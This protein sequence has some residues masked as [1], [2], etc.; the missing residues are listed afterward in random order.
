MDNEEEQFL[1]K[2]KE[3]VQ[4][5]SEA[6]KEV[7]EGL[8]VKQSNLIEST[9]TSSTLDDNKETSTTKDA[10]AISVSEQEDSA[11][12]TGA[13]VGDLEVKTSEGLEITLTTTAASQELS[14]RADVDQEN[15]VEIETEIS[16]LNQVPDVV[17]ETNETATVTTPE[18]REVTETTT[19]ATETAETTT[20]QENT[21][22]KEHVPEDETVGYC[23]LENEKS[24]FRGWWK[25]L[26]R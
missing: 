23:I 17:A 1:T 12:S 20:E 22:T 25:R 4:N 3:N 5:C 19:I 14:K 26:K 8:D 9:A 13:P 24:S 18:A 6:M 2:L 11:S 21:E 7:N 10:A 16:K 15:L